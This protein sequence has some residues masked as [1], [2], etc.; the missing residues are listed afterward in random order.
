MRQT[1]QESSPEA[2]KV[3]QRETQEF[4][5]SKA[6]ADAMKANAINSIENGRFSRLRPIIPVDG[7]DDVEGRFEG[8]FVS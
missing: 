8:C 1:C 2:E 3:N 7:G 6:K 5:N 4:T